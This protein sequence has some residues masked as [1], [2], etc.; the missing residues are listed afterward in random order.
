MPAIAI[1]NPVMFQKLLIFLNSM[2]VPARMPVVA[3]VASKVQGRF[4]RVMAGREV[5]KLSIPQMWCMSILSPKTALKLSLNEEN[6]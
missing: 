1:I 6:S 3:T 2:Y 4:F 5:G